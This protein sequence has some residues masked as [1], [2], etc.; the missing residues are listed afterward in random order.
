[1]SCMRCKKGGFA[2]KIDLEKAF[3]HLKW[4]FNEN[5]L[6]EVSLDEKLVGLIMRCITTTS[7]NILCNDNM[8][9]FFNSL[10]V[11]D[12]A[13]LSSLISL[14]YAWKKFSHIICEEFDKKKW[15][16]IWVGKKGPSISHLMFAD[17][18]IFFWEASINQ[19]TC[20]NNCINMFCGMS[21]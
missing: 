1:M 11:L 6:K 7:Y 12:K 16:P 4:S 5:I 15:F 2:I 19:M 14:F 3:D 20:I 10:E 18:L 17:S 13:T 8:T 21:G 9:E